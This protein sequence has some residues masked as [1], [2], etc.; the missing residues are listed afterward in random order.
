MKEQWRHGE[1]AFDDEAGLEVAV[2][3][4]VQD[5]IHQLYEAEVCGLNRSPV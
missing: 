1:A 3:R 2:Q 4:E 5:K